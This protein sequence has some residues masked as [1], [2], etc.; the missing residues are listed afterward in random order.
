VFPDNG[1]PDG[2]AAA[3]RAGDLNDPIAHGAH[4]VAQP[5]TGAAAEA[6]GAGHRTGQ[7]P[8]PISPKSELSVG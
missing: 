1:W 2:Q 6:H 8:H 7:H 4:A 3:V 5:R